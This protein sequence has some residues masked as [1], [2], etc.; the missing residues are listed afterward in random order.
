[1]ATRVALYL[2]VSTTG[3]G[4]TTENQRRELVAVGERLGWEI[5]QVFEDMVSGSKGRQARPGLDALMKGIARRSFDLVAAWSVDRLGRSL[6][7]LIG[8]LNELHAKKVDLYLHQQGL[9][10]S[11]PAGRAFYSV[12][13]TFAEFERSLIQT[14]IVAGLAR[15]KAEGR[16]LGR[17]PVGAEVEDNI[18]KARQSGMG[19]RRIA[20]EIGCGVSVVQ[21]V[22]GEMRKSGATASKP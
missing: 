5:V 12:L 17:K 18:R 11:T 6:Q 19:I 9:D 8:F 3:H 21:R 2:R 13:G 20:R 14:R 7:D 15:A 1:M 10:T 4:Q 22:V 16:R